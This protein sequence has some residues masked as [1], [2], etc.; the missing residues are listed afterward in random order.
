M[1][2]PQ[3]GKI[4]KRGVNKETGISVCKETNVGHLY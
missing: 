3:F 4:F 1:L 2:S